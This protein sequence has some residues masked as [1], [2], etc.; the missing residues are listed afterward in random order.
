[1]ASR[2]SRRMHTTAHVHPH[3]SDTVSAVS[4]CVAL[5]LYILLSMARYAGCRPRTQ[6]SIKWIVTSNVTVNRI[7][8][9]NTHHHHASDITSHDIMQ[10]ATEKQRQRRQQ[11]HHTSHI[12]SHITHHTS[13]ITAT[14]H[15]MTYDVNRIRPTCNN[16]SNSNITHH[17]ISRI[18]HH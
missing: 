9:S 18:T 16:S 4:A 3:T 5:T 17:I 6:C 8:P 12:T 2:R 10:R 1:M 13:H 11:Q 7:R 15:D 14:R